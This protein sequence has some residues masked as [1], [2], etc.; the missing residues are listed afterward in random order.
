MSQLT[1]KVLLDTNKMRVESVLLR[2][3]FQLEELS[4]MTRPELNSQGAM[5]DPNEPGVLWIPLR[6]RAGQEGLERLNN[7]Q[8]RLFDELIA[9][10][11]R[12]DGLELNRVDGRWRSD[13]VR[14]FRATETCVSCHNV[15]GSAGA[16][17]LHEVV[18]VAAVRARGIGSD[19]RKT[20]FL[21]RVWTVSAG[22]IGATGAM[23]LGT[24]L[25]EL[26][27]RNL[28]RGLCTLCAGGGIGI[29]TI[30]ERV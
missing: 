16:F 23:I 1:K 5:R 12:D 9:D 29:A 20:V 28:R 24:L 13:Y 3:H 19:L 21:N 4:R 22:L 11:T 30:I 26:E 7:A 10:E 27:R 2:T 18:G 25:D 8:R 15:Q 14:L 6:G 17:A